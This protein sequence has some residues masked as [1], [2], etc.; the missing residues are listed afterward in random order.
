MPLRGAWALKEL[1]GSSGAAVWHPAFS[2]NSRVEVTATI[3][4]QQDREY[5]FLNGGCR[6]VKISRPSKLAFACP[7]ILK[8]FRWKKFCVNDK[9]RASRVVDAKMAAASAENRLEQRCP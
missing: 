2:N 8:L 4:A 6:N 1:C 5:K 7:D 3:D 9:G